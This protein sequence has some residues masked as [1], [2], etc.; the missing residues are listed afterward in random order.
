M[1]TLSL[2]KFSLS[3]YM[4][5]TFITILAL[6]NTI[7]IFQHCDQETDPKLPKL[8]TSPVTEI[9]HMTASS[10]GEILSDGDAS[11]TH[12]GV[13]WSI[14]AS[15]TLDDDK[16]EDGS[17][18][19]VFT[20]SLTG[21]AGGTTYHIRAYA[22]N[23]VGTAYGDEIE[24]TT[25]PT[26][27]VP[28]VSTM[29]ASNITTNAAS[30][31]GNV[32]SDGNSAVTARGVCWSTTTLPTISDNKTSDGVGEGEFVSTLTP[33]S[34][35]TTYFVRA[36]AT[37]DVGTS[38]GNEVS[39]STNS[40]TTTL[41]A[42]KDGTIFNNQAGN[43]ANGNYGAGGSELLQVGYASP[44]AIYAR[45][46]VQFDL[47][48]IPSNAI[49]ESVSLEFTLG[50]SGS[51]VPTIYVHN[52]SQTWV[53]GTTS[54]CTYNN[55][56]NTQGVA[57]TPGGTDV[58][59]NETS[60]SGTAINPWNTLGGTFNST[61]SAVSTDLGASSILYLSEGLKNDVQ[62]WVSN[63]SINFGWLLKTDFIT[64]TSAMRRFRSREGAIASGDLTSAPRLTIIYH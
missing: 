56:C 7:F 10:G 23:K 4:N 6:L 2:A 52:V 40:I 19:G 9:S 63:P 26:P 3:I 48:A 8:T 39:F 58:T 32:S 18:V 50:S 55:P 21:L 1:L 47:S 53:E 11:I 24:F 43:S 28:V 41:Y 31:G 49:I 57:I 27:T 17:D 29:V 60:Y 25:S 20:S 22:T 30:S 44:T 5:K 61:A 36:Y 13:C 59:W 51:F 33:L 35:G 46:L 12:R 42:V 16:T 45:T 62:S 54:F 37:N 34:A 38:Y 14:S 15:P 64:N